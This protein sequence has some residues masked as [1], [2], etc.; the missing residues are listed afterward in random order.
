[1]KAFKKILIIFGLSI[2]ILFVA[3]IKSNATSINSTDVTIYTCADQMIEYNHIM[4]SEYPTSFQLK[5]DGEIKS[6]KCKQLFN[7]IVF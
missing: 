4:P 7:W 6:P 3:S 5:F 1:M 2:I